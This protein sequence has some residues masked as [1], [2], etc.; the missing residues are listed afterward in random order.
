[1]PETPTPIEIEV[2]LRASRQAFADLA[3]VG[4]FGPW[5]V[6]EQTE[7]RLRDTYF[8][9]PG[10]ALAR[11]RCT[12]RIRSLDGEAIGEL[13]LKGPA[14]DAPGGPLARTELTVAIPV[15]I[16]VHEWDTITE[17]RP[18]I[19]ALRIRGIAYPGDLVGGA[20]LVNPR[21]NLRLRRDTNAGHAHDH[22]EVI[23]SL[24][25]VRLEGHPYL[26]RYVEIELVRGVPEAIVEVS[27]LVAG[28][29][30]L[31]PAR[32]GKVQAARAWLA[33]LHP[34]PSV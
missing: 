26:R 32:S 28:M 17:A 8:D 24:D 4:A 23:L 15:G 3:E 10:H 34:N 5:R 33:R 11:Q 6:V 20:V 18:V 19:E 31:R 21:R 29:T 30:R 14:G 16:G 2:K 7:I 13:T 9:T 1:M 22:A 25:E 12:L 27:N